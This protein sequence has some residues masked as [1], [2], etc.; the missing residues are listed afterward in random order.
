M[1]NVRSNVIGTIHPI[2]WSDIPA[3]KMTELWKVM[4]EKKIHQGQRGQQRNRRALT[5]SCTEHGP[6]YNTPAGIAWT[7]TKFPGM[8]SIMHRAR[9][10]F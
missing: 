10:M 4:M 7:T 6:C 3:L 5:A 2:T 1:E 9:A 8:D